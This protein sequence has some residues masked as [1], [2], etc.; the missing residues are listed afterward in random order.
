MIVFDITSKTP[1][2]VV[3]N[4]FTADKVAADNFLL[5]QVFKS[6]IEIIYKKYSINEKEFMKEL[7]LRK[8]N[9]DRGVLQ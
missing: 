4:V 7:K 9:H 2:G 6:E 8:L 5:K 3:D 1:T